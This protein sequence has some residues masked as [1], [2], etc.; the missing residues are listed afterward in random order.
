MRVISCHFL[1]IRRHLDHT[2]IL[3]YCCVVLIQ[4]QLDLS[5]LKYFEPCFCCSIYVKTMQKMRRKPQHIANVGSDVTHMYM[6]KFCV[7]YAAVSDSEDK[8]IINK[9]MTISQSPNT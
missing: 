8:T 7:I 4:T 2:S 1:V 9:S 6:L 3:K 5:R